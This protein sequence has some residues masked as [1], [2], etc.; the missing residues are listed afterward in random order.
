MGRVNAYG[1]LSRITTSDLLTVTV[2]S[3][4]SGVNTSITPLE[5]VS[6]NGFDPDALVSLRKTGQADIN[7]TGITIISPTKI[8]CTFDL[9]GKQTGLWDVVVTNP[10]GQS[11]TLPGGFSITAPPLPPVLSVTGISPGSGFNN[12]TVSIT[13]LSGTGFVSG[14]FPSLRKIGPGGYQRYR[15]H[16]RIF[17][18]DHL[19]IQPERKK[20]RILGYRRD[21][22]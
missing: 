18:K 5:S 10:E 15:G 4:S 2:I 9:N 3:P 6:G 17:H 16:D 21:E 12:R 14:Y 1:V 8:T 20:G 11:T 13:N 22:T 7:G 19:Y